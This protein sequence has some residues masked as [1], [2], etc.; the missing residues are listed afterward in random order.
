MKKI[1]VLMT[2]LSIILSSCGTRTA[3]KSEESTTD[4]TEITSTDS[5]ASDAV[6]TVSAEQL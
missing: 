3:N 4:T 2:V 1:F 6:D 5:T